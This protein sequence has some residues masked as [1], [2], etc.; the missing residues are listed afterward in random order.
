[1]PSSVHVGAC[2]ALDGTTSNVP[3]TTAT[4]T[5]ATIDGMEGQGQSLDDF[6]REHALDEDCAARLRRL[7]DVQLALVMQKDL[8]TARN[9]SAMLNMTC[10]RFERSW[11][12]QRKQQR[13]QQ[14]QQQQEQEQHQQAV[15]CEPCDGASNEGPLVARRA[16]SDKRR[17][18]R[19]NKAA[20][21]DRLLDRILNPLRADRLVTARL[22]D[23]MQPLSTT[24]EPSEG[25]LDWIGMGA[26]CD[27]FRVA[28]RL[29]DT[30]CGKRKR[31]SIAAFA[32]LLE[33]VLLPS[34]QAARAEEPA[35]S[36]PGGDQGTSDRR[37]HPITIV[38]AGCSTG[39]LIL[40]LAHAFPE[41]RFVGI[42]VKAS[43]LLMLR[44][45]AAAAGIEA[46]VSTW[47]GRIEEYDGPCDAVVSLHACGGASDAALQL[48]ARS[49]PTGRRAAPFAVSPCCVGALPFG[50]RS[51]GDKK[52][53]SR[54]RG[55]ASA[56]LGAHILS[57]AAAEDEMGRG[58][59][60]GGG[61][62]LHGA[63]EAEFFAL[64][65]AS[66]GSDG[67]AQQGLEG[68]AACREHAAARRRRSKRVLEIDRLAA[69]PGDGLGGVMMT[70]AGEAIA[71]SSS[72]TDVLV[73]PP[74]SLTASLCGG[75]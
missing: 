73:G 56:W 57:A 35:A 13:Q 7:T 37:A 45:R 17:A 69:M 59:H 29:A 43:S 52:E 60:G 28:P 50:I 63:K 36:A 33:Q 38:D 30:A 75:A 15:P 58:G 64:L 65:A 41:A 8:S 25:R 34:V 14:Q 1:M 55:A 62:T 19:A 12:Q 32:W 23:M 51:L 72:L 67:S 61:N 74:S 16:R 18:N 9:A 71:S 70:I 39:S 3:T 11:Q 21:L 66:A 24:G 26:T 10:N 5:A 20:R 49:A 44:E 54:A 22:L 4:A 31:E 68:E 47:E 6:I 27:P 53:G 2:A 40:P 46:R 42:D 48:A